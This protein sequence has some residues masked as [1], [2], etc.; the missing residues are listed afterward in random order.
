MH[1]GGGPAVPVGHV[2]LVVVAARRDEV[3]GADRLPGSDADRASV[4]DDAG[5]DEPVADRRV[6]TRGLLARVHHDGE[7]APR[8]ASSD[9][10]VGDRLLPLVLAGVQLELA[11][12]LEGVEHL[13]W[14][15]PLAHLQGEYRE[16]GVRH[17]RQRAVVGDRF[18]REPVDHLQVDACGGI[19][20]AV[21]EVEHTAAADRR[22]LVAV[23]N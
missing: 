4:I 9:D 13:G 19:G 12:R 5:G 10:L 3:T 16:H 7:R 2:E 22:E 14:V 21:R 20:P 11:A 18:A 6:Q 17:P 1:V 23:A 15:V 8:A